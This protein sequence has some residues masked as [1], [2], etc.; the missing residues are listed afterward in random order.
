MK[1]V[2]PNEKSIIKIFSIDLQREEKALYSKFRKRLLRLRKD[3]SI[4]KTTFD[5]LSYIL[6]GGT[7]D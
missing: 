2:K 5:N 1:S 4:S 3:E 7:N 6:G